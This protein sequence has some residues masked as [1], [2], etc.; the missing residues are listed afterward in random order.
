MRVYVETN[1]L[2]E[3][4]CLQ[5]QHPSCEQILDWCEAGSI[6]LAMPAFCLPEAHFTL[7]GKLKR[8][9]RFLRYFQ[10][11]RTEM[12]RSFHFKDQTDL[13]G[14]IDG[15]LTASFDHENKEFDK[16]W[17]RLMAIAELIPLNADTLRTGAALIATAHLQLPDALIVSSVITHLDAF[18]LS[19]SCF[20]NRDRDFRKPYITQELTRRGC[21]LLFNFEDGA[22]YLRSSLVS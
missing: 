7:V 12:V 5:E 19:E 16:I 17:S 18:P 22:D 14:A 8:R 13:L 1:F 6:S 20:L 21:K 3:L 15:F 9:E 11:Q 4:V 2:I 10:E